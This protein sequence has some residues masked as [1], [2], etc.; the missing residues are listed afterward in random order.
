MENKD[1]KNISMTDQN[2]LLSNSGGDDAQPPQQIN[3]KIDLIENFLS[4]MANK[5]QI[6]DEQL[7]GI[8]ILFKE[9]LESSISKLKEDYILNEADPLITSFRTE[10]ELFLQAKLSIIQDKIKENC[11]F[12]ADIN[13]FVPT[14]ESKLLDNLVITITHFKTQCKVSNIIKE[15]VQNAIKKKVSFKVDSNEKLDNT[16]RKNYYFRPTRTCARPQNEKKEDLSS[17]KQ[18]K[19]KIPEGALRVLKEWLLQNVTDPY[20]SKEI[21]QELAI[22]AGIGIK[23]VHNWFINA[24]G[25]ICKKLYHN[26]KFGKLVENCYIKTV[27]PKI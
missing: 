26:E 3:G 7:C 2:S 12:G 18:K 16:N 24:R 11:F 25:R 21:K 27:N 5:T 13:K 6:I 1:E 20:P 10:N 22:K 17:H 9:R 8:K 23:Q 4:L 15:K 19:T 14:I